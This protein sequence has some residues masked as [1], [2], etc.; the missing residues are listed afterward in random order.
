MPVDNL[1]GVV[2]AKERTIASASAFFVPA[3]A[4]EDQERVYA[5]LAQWCHR[6][7]PQ[8][9]ARIYSITYVHDGE[10]WTAT[11]GES[12][13]GVRR[14]KSRARGARVERVVH[15]TDPATVLAIFPDVPY[16]V[17]TNHRIAG[18]V[19]SAWENPFMA[20]Q[21]QSVTYFSVAR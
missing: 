8:T 6:A 14:K 3:A 19:R 20:G 4:P 1:H 9:E 16:L 2:S 21:P 10:E 5:G 17:V 15:L 11:V 7:V 18:S 12:L 13:R